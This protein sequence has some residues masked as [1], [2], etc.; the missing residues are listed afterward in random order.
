MEE[1]TQLIELLKL[2]GFK[3]EGWFSCWKYFRKDAICIT[4]DVDDLSLD[5]LIKLIN[6]E[7]LERTQTD[8]V[9]GFTA[10]KTYIEQFI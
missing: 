5:V 1:S 10:C 3:E 6:T 8:I 4:L 7:S 2:K 9:R